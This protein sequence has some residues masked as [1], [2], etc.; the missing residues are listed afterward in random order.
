MAGAHQEKEPA[1]PGRRA[2]PGEVCQG[3]VL[4]AAARR[5]DGVQEHALPQA[6]RNNER[7][8]RRI[9]G[10]GTRGAS[11]G[12]LAEDWDLRVDPH[13]V[14]AADVQGENADQY[15]FSQDADPGNAE[16]GSRSE[17]HTSEL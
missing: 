12:Y 13:L 10:L 17:E 15:S 14:F 6:L 5:H 9:S 4:H 2:G 16:P 8:E 7:A 11:D 3:A 1:A